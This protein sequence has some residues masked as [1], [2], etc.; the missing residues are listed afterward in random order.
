MYSKDVFDN[1]LTKVSIPV[2]LNG[3]LVFADFHTDSIFYYISGDVCIPQ[4]H[5]VV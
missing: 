5:V 2:I 3:L 4:Q 1:Q